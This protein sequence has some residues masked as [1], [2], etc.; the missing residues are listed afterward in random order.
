MT[1][2]NR[3]T[4]GIPTPSGFDIEAWFYQPEGRARFPRW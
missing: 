3:T 1:A 4:V 2:V